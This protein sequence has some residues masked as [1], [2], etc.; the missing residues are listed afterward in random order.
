MKEVRRALERAGFAVSK[1]RGGHWKF[2]HPNLDGPVFASDTPSDHR[3]IK[4]LMA[5]LRRKLR[6]SNDN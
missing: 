4:N 1:T 3:G 5:M 2:E 6:V